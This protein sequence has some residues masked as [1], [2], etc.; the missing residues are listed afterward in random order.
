MALHLVKF[1]HAETLHAPGF[2]DDGRTYIASSAICDPPRR[3]SNMPIEEDEE[4][5]PNYVTCHPLYWDDE[6][7]E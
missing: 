5:W 7:P 2:R 6:L 1:M 4:S 3:V